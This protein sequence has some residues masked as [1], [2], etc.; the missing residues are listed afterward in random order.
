MDYYVNSALRLRL[1]F[2]QPNH[3]AVALVM[4]WGVALAFGEKFQIPK[5]QIPNKFQIP[6]DQIP[7]QASKRIFAWLKMGVLSLVVVA[8]LVGLAVTYSRSG[9]VALFV[10]GCVL[11]RFQ[12][13]HRWIVMSIAVMTIC[14]VV[15][16][17]VSGRFASIEPFADKSISHRFD[18]WRGTL[19]MSIERPWTG[20]G[21]LGF[22]ETLGTWHLPEGLSH[23]NTRYRSAVNA[24]MTF[25]GYWGYPALFGY[26]CVWLL[27]LFAGF[28]GWW[29]IE[30]VG[31]D[32]RAVRSGGLGETALPDDSSNHQ[33]NNKAIVA[34]FIVQLAFLVGGVFTHLH[35]SRILH[36]VLLVSI[37]GTIVF[38]RNDAQAWRLLW[39]RW[40]PV[41]ASVSL[42]ICGLLAAAGAWVFSEGYALRGFPLD[43]QGK[44][45]GQGWVLVPDKPNGSRLVWFIPHG[46][47]REHARLLCRPLA[48]RG[49]EVVILEAGEGEI[50]KA[51]KALA[52]LKIPN[53]KGRDYVASHGLEARATSDERDGVVSDGG[54]RF[55]VGGVG[56][57]GL[58]ALALASKLSL[59]EGIVCE[60][61]V[62]NIESYWPFEEFNPQNTIKT[63]GGQVVLAFEKNNARFAQAAGALADVGGKNGKRVALLPLDAVGEKEILSVLRMRFFRQN[64]QN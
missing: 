35:Q 2:D 36:F 24:P 10:V 33:V 13:A 60:I 30:E 37:C 43:T 47:V 23:A 18:V 50:L 12:D 31:T 39:R 29:R 59:D 54:A 3:L 22:G 25:L 57:E 62:V 11:W 51:E 44:S 14:F 49:W 38:H 27:L 17:E 20:F 40:L 7:K 48:K 55:V 56:E 63:V 34:C 4:A 9:L 16:P 58:A 61:V 53:L 42:V 1:F 19:A 52:G 45:T 5:S 46:V 64:E 41:A 26:L 15:I 6:N 28:R 32:R 8:S 21:S